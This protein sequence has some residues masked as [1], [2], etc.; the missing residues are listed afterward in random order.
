MGWQLSG[1][2]TCWG[3]QAGGVTNGGLVWR[4]CMQT[5]KKKK[6]D[7]NPTPMFGILYVTPPSNS[8]FVL[9]KLSIKLINWTTS[10]R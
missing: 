4:F 2:H 9:E 5:K 1:E 6:T 3:L 10:S 7:A 8:K